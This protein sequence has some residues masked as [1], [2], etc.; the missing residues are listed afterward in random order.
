MMRDA[1]CFAR[2]TAT[3]VCVLS[4]VDVVFVPCS[5]SAVTVLQPGRPFVDARPPSLTLPRVFI[6]LATSP[7]LAKTTA[8]FEALCTGSSG[9]MKKAPHKKLHYEGCPI[10]R[11]ESNFV[12]QGGDVTR[13][14]GSGGASICA[15][16]ASC[17]EKRPLK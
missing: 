9:S 3:D 8:N 11:V 1:S 16:A 12:V 13:G 4:S 6:D 10:H 15:S 2:R 14:D 17:S 7:G 5:T